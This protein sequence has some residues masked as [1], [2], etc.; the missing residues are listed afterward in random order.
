MNNRDAKEVLF[1]QIFESV[2]RLKQAKFG[3]SLEEIVP[4]HDNSFYLPEKNKY[5]NSKENQ[6]KAQ[7][8][9]SIDSDKSIDISIKEVIN[10]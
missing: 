1:S 5:W 8:N 9:N 2:L 10:E 6:K 4:E 3:H 7:N